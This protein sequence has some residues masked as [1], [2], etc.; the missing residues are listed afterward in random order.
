MS[1]WSEIHAGVPQGTRLGPVIF[2]AM[3]NGASAPQ[4]TSVYKYVDDIALV[5]C[6][7]SNQHSSVQEAVSSL[8]S[9]SERSKMSLNPP[10]CATMEITFARNPPD[11]PQILLEDQYL[12]SVKI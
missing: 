11:P 1:D 5:E 7:S 8:S 9:W 12:K 4:G 3:I 6:R 2:L 10:K